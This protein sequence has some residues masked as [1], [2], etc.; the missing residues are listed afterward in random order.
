[1][2]LPQK[3]H[4]KYHIPEFTKVLKGSRNLCDIGS[5]KHFSD[6]GTKILKR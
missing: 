1:M 5:G 4:R 2:N 6:I 3:N